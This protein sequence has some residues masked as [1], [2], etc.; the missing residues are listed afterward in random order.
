M[1]IHI[2]ITS[3]SRP[4]RSGAEGPPLNNMPLVVKIRSLRYASLRSASVETTEQARVIMLWCARSTRKGGECLAHIGSGRGLRSALTHQPHGV[5]DPGE[6]GQG[7]AQ[8]GILEA[9]AH[10][11]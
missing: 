7:C 6:I 1:M 5:F 9:D 8:G 3:S 11:T 2:R 4:K 10:V